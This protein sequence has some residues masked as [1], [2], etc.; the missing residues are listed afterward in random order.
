MSSSSP[1]SWTGARPPLMASTVS[2][3]TSTPCTVFPLSASTAAMTEP[4]FP[5]PITEMFILKFNLYVM[6]KEIF[7]PVYEVALRGAN[8]LTQG[9]RRIIGLMPVGVKVLV[10]GA[11]GFIGHHLVTQLKGLGYWVRGADLKLPEFCRSAADEF[12]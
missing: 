11:G 9:C 3:F 1:G 7:G 6:E 12:Q 5:R 10:T 4:S 8:G 2:G